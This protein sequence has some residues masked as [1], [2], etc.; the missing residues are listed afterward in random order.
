MPERQIR[1]AIIPEAEW[2]DEFQTEQHRSC[3]R[4]KESEALILMKNK[5]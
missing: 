1:P 3:E 2:L 5:D 4:L